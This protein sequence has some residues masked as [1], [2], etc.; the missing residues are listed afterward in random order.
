[1]DRLSSSLELAASMVGCLMTQRD[2]GTIDWQ[3][4]PIRIASDV[5]V[6]PVRETGEPIYRIEIPATHEFFRVGLPEYTFLSALDGHRTIAQACGLVTAKMGRGAP[7]SSQCESIA[8]WLIDHQL[9]HFAD[10]PPPRRGRSGQT[11][12]ASE[13]KAKSLTRWNPFWIKTPIPGAA[14][15]LL[16]LSRAL[17]FLFTTPMLV[18]GVLSIVAAL[19]GL[20]TRWSEF[21]AG[22]ASIFDPSNWAW[23]LLTAIGLKLVHELGHAIA[24]HRAGGTVREAGVVWVLMTPLAYVDVSSCWRLSS[25]WSRIGVAAAGMLIE[26]WV[27]SVAIAGWLFCESEIIRWWCHHV[28]LTAGLSTVLFNANVLM[29]FDGYFM[30]SDW[31][32]VPNLATEANQSVRQFLRRW[33]LGDASW[34][35]SHTGWRRTAVFVYGWCAVAWRVLVCVSLG[36]AASTMLGGAGV[37][38][39]LLGGWMWWGKPFVTWLQ[40]MRTLWGIHPLQV[41][42][43]L[44]LGSL[45]VGMLG[46][47]LVAMPVPSSIRVPVVVQYRPESA[48]RVGVEGFLVELLVHEGDQVQAGDR[49]AV[50]ENRELQQRVAELE[51]AQ[52]QNDIRLRK[53][54]ESREESERLILLD[55]RQAISDKLQTLRKQSAQLQ[56]RAVQSGR[57]IAEDLPSKLNTYV[58]EGDVLMVVATPTD[59]EVLAVVNQSQ[60]EDVR[61]RMGESVRLVSAGRQTFWGTLDQLQPRASDRVP[62]ASLAATHGGPLAVRMDDDSSTESSREDRLGETTIDAMRLLQ[63]HFRGVVKLSETEAKRVPAGMRL[64]AHFGWHQAPIATRLKHWFQNALAEAAETAD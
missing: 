2:P 13:T 54:I 25:R 44:V 19:L 31:M 57:V 20:T 29:R 6:W 26:G 17:G 42:R 27:A 15:L 18:V 22:A 16:P 52:Q 38:L 5:K 63:P 24:C 23:L 14:K 7:S 21:L 34:V 32:D 4:Q 45:A 30:L 46:W 1:M 37:L 48:V 61:Q 49:L 43:G 41:C 56:V 60:V 53:A 64:E 11:A 8:R 35:R 55:N 36:I 58:K 9:A 59:K 33:F 62:N 10:A 50:I 39:S 40:S 28:I 47:M 51:I 3:Q 12:S